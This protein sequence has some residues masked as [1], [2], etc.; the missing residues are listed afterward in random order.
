MLASEWFEDQAEGLGAQFLAAAGHTIDAIQAHPE[1]FARVDAS[2]RV[3]RA[4]LKRFPYG[5]YYVFNGR[6]I[7]ILALFHL[8]R[9]PASLQDRLRLALLNVK[10]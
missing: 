4:M 6:S 2:R 10:P 3:R 8:R 1:R 5:V 7:F 9:D